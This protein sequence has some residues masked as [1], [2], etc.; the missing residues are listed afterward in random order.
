MSKFKAILLLIILVTPLPAFSASADSVYSPTSNFSYSGGGGTPN[1]V[2]KSYY[3]NG[4]RTVR[5][6]NYKFCTLLG[7]VVTN[8]GWYIYHV[9]KSGSTWYLSNGNTDGPA[10]MYVACY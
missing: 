8:G 5:V 7:V 2:Y 1:W 9:H 6:G 3:F 10:H 4:S